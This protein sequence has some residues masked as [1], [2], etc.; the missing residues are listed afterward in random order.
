MCV[1]SSWA[2]NWISVSRPTVGANVLPT[3]DQPKIFASVQATVNL[4]YAIWNA[5]NDLIG[6][7]SLCEAYLIDEKSLNFFHVMLKFNQMRFVLNFHLTFFDLEHVRPTNRMIFSFEQ[8]EV[9]VFIHLP[10][11]SFVT[12]WDQMN[13]S[14]CRCCGTESTNIHNHSDVRIAG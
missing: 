14:L 7:F 5:W 2:L 8:S 4:K 3:T 9:R 1:W 13:T 10:T 12:R 11:Q 6:I